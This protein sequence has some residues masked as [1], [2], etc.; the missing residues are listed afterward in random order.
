MN[1]P[2]R[3]DVDLLDVAILAGP[4]ALFAGVWI[5]LGLG[6]ALIA[7]GAVAWL[8]VTVILAVRARRVASSTNVR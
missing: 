4:A 7:V 5:E 3:P 1:T 2:E 6:I 8:Q